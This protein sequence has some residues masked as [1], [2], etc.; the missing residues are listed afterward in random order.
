[1]I[2]SIIIL[3]SKIFY[4]ISIKIINKN[5]KYF[6]LIS[7]ILISGIKLYGILRNFY[8]LDVLNL[9]SDGSFNLDNFD[10][11]SEP[12]PGPSGP[13]EPTEPTG[14]T[15][16]TG[17]I[18][19]KDFGRYIS[20]LTPKFPDDRD[21]AE[22]WANI[23]RHPLMTPEYCAQLRANP[24]AVNALYFANQGRLAALN[25]GLLEN[26][27]GFKEFVEIYIDHNMSMVEIIQKM[28]QSGQ[29]GQCIG[30]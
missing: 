28:S 24:N 3:F 11:N 5:L 27:V 21:I 9:A 22:I 18:E 12:T 16:P 26:S 6:I 25:A 13:T 7:S 8:F 23:N 30:F 10:P 1:M 15:G 17:A 19:P 20:N 14:P 2:K 4:F 29:S